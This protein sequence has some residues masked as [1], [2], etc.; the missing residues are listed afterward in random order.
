VS[1]VRYIPWREVGARR[2]I[3]VDGAPLVSTVLTLSHW[4]NN[5]TPEPFRRDT[6]TETALAYVAGH[7]PARTATIVT[8]NHY[9]E[10]GLFSMFAVTEPRWALAAGD[11]LADAARAGDFGT[12]RTRDGARLFFVIEAHADPARSPLPPAVFAASG[13]ARVA[14]QY[15]AMLPR[16]PRLIEALPSLARLWRDEEAHLEESE[17]LIASGRAIIEE[18]PELDLAVIRIPQDCPRRPVRRYLG[19]ERMALHPIAVHNATRCTRLVRIQG[20]AIELQ[21]RYESWLSLPSRRPAQRVDLAPFCR[22]LNRR[23]RNGRW[24]WEDTLGIAPRL[25]LRGEGSSSIVPATFLRELRRALGRL[26]GV[27]DPYNWTL[28]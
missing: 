25:F 26:H 20:R 2:N 27:W 9:D 10:D 14:A 1:R 11:L 5:A 15:R 3:V 6:S 16:L 17:S 21:Y 8:N 4:P 13:A 23:E 24:I 19:E 18:E 22:W 7:D 12:C 28:A